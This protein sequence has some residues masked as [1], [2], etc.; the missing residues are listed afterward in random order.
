MSS[1]EARRA[2]FNELDIPTLPVAVVESI[3]SYGIAEDGETLI[4]LVELADGSTASVGI[5]PG[6]PISVHVVMA[7]ERPNKALH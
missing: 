6:Q 1:N 7:S 3:N 4:V 5:T 2:V